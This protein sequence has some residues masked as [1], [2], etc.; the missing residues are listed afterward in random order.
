LRGVAQFIHFC[1]FCSLV[2]SITTCFFLCPYSSLKVVGL[3]YWVKHDGFF[4]NSYVF[5]SFCGGTYSFLISHVCDCLSSSSVWSIPL[6]I[7]CSA[8]LVVINCY[9]LCLSWTIFISSILKD[10]FAGWSNFAW[11]LLLG[12]EI[13]HSMLFWL[14]R[15]LL[16]GLIE[17]WCFCLCKYVDIFI[18][19]LSISFLWSLPLNI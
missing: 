12:L 15:L 9:S 13:C 6:S 5:I 16:R 14:S 11:Q 3:Y 17:F 7:F 8:G 1:W 4:P 18:L 19:Q 10:Y 2:G